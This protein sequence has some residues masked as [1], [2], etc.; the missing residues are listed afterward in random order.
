MPR[1]ASARFSRRGAESS[2]D[3]AEH[4]P[5]I[6][7]RVYG[8]GGAWSADNGRTWTA[9]AKPPGGKG[10]GAVAV[11]ADGTTVVWSPDS[12]AVIRSTDHGGT[13]A[14]VKGLPPKA[15]IVSDRVAPKDFYGVDEPT[16]TLYAS[17]D[18]GA[19]L[20]PGEGSSEGRSIS[21]SRAGACRRSVALLVA[22]T[23]PLN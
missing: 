13:W 17:A 10:D 2:I 19:T 12:A 18:S 15:R 21:P 22:G 4:Q 9:F 20:R 1:R 16:G 23:I 8:G 7:A 14:A 11:S 5:E 3:F 6:I